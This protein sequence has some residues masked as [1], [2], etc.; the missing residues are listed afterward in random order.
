MEKTIVDFILVVSSIY[1]CKSSHSGSSQWAGLSPQ[2]QGRVSLGGRAVVSPQAALALRGVFCLGTMAS[3]IKWMTQHWDPCSYSICSLP[4]SSVPSLSSGISNPLF[5]IFEGP[6]VSD[7][8]WKCVL[9]PFKWV[10]ASPAVHLWQRATLLYFADG[11]YL[12]N[13]WG[14]V[15]GL[16][17]PT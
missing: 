5:S 1:H 3:A 13:F 8:K 17:I 15:S 16:G 6:Q 12:C 10:F 9:W 14:L 4:E 2:S 11:H 7:S